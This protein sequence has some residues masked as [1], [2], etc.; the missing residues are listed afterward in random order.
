MPNP[1]SLF[2]FKVLKEIL[3]DLYINTAKLFKAKI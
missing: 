2:I 3:E 1:G